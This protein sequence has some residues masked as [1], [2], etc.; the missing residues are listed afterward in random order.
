MHRLNQY[1]VSDLI[2]TS[3]TMTT[4]WSI[5]NGLFTVILQEGSVFRF[6]STNIN[7]KS[8]LY[9]QG[10]TEFCTTNIKPGV[11]EAVLSIPGNYI[12]QPQAIE[13]PSIPFITLDTQ[14]SPAPQ[15]GIDSVVSSY[16][17]IA[18]P[19]PKKTILY[20]QP[21]SIIKEVVTEI[22]EAVVQE[23]S[24]MYNSTNMEVYI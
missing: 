13:C 15:A 14:A 18:A 1:L 23:L 17:A 6:K 11:T 20:S 8:I 7:V 24:K 2:I 3:Y 5:D 16:Q 4:K 9:K 12:V 10:N 21:I 19:D 22:S